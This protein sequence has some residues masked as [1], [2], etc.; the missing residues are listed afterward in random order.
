MC[1]VAASGFVDIHTFNSE[2]DS[3]MAWWQDVCS[4]ARQTAG[5]IVF[6]KLLVCSL[7]CDEWLTT[8][9]IPPTSICERAMVVSAVGSTW[10]TSPV[11]KGHED[12]WSAQS[13]HF[14][15]RIYLTIQINCQC[16]HR[17]LESRMFLQLIVQIIGNINMWIANIRLLKIQAHCEFILCLYMCI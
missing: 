12:G 5:P 7:S 13:S 8:S 16:N 6:S 15:S 3:A 4:L 11:H 2:R 17:N 10:V 9:S 14:T 1:K